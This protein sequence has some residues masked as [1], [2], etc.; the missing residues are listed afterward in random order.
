MTARC[1]PLQMQASLHAET[2]HLSTNISQVLLQHHPSSGQVQ[3]TRHMGTRF[4]ASSSQIRNATTGV[5]GQS[6]DLPAAIFSLQPPPHIDTAVVA[7]HNDGDDD[8]K[9]HD[10]KHHDVEHHDVEHD[11]GRERRSQDMTRAVEGRQ[12]LAPISIY[13][14]SENELCRMACSSD[15]TRESTVVKDNKLPTLAW[16]NMLIF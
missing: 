7:R 13:I 5:G 6:S 3:P 11:G 14:L 12:G 1:F 9:H 8:G 15:S 2:Q 16:T 10:D 4:A